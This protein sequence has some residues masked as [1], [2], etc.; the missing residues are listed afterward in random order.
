MLFTGDDF[1][2]R[3]DDFD[4]FSRFSLLPPPDSAADRLLSVVLPE[5][6]NDFGVGDV[7]KL[8]HV[9]VASLLR[10]ELPLDEFSRFDL[11]RFSDLL[12]DVVGVLVVVVVVVVSP[13]TASLLPFLV[14]VVVVVCVVVGVV[15]PLVRPPA[16]GVL[17]AV[18]RC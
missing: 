13:V 14:V 16:S 17:A 6:F 2:S 1:L 3:S 8:G 12:D 5:C 9:C 11:S 4:D 18:S 15:S 10:F 7:V